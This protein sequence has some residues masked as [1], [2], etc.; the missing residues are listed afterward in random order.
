MG[1]LILGYNILGNRIVLCRDSMFRMSKIVGYNIWE[2][3]YITLFFF[4]RYELA[5]QYW[6]IQY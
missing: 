1:L 6:Y 4:S 3:H 5:I 2:G